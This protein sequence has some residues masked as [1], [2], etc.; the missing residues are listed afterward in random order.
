MAGS[1]PPERGG[2]LLTVLG[3]FVLPNGGA[4]WTQTLLA[5]LDQLG[6]KDKAA[7]QSIARLH[8]RGWL[9]R[10]KVGRQTRWH[11]TERSEQLLADGASRIYG[12]GH[13]RR[14]WDEQWSILLTTVPEGD[15]QL[16]Y[17]MG[18]EL[19]WVGYGSLGHG[20]WISPWA[21]REKAAADIVAT[22]G[23]DATSFQGTLGHLG[24][25]TGLADQAWDLPDL[26]DG[27]QRFLDQ[28]DR[29][30][31]ELD[32]DDGAAAAAALTTIVHRWRRFPF[33]DP[34]LPSELL[35]VGW[36]GAVAVER[37][38]QLRDR[39]LEPATTWW[40]QTDADATP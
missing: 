5:V 29:V 4:A 22:L 1:G 31:D 6:V 2:V 35:P 17:R 39:L 28:C 33:D 14:P 40:R 7:R 20:A 21:D 11:L 32:H 38:G 9:D 12:F 23:I 8:E 36:P 3:E 19:G 16:R 10:T 26:R 24:S 30:S 25:S 18:V 37:F 13:D 27:Y 15:R 34:D